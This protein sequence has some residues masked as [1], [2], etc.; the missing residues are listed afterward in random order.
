MIFDTAWAHQR[1]VLPTL[2]ARNHLLLWDP[3]TGKTLPLLAAAAARGGRCLYLLPP[4]VRTQV[5]R[6]A[7]RFGLF[8]P[9]DVQVVLRNADRVSLAAKLVVCSYEQCHTPALWRQLFALDWATLV[10]DEAHL[11]KNGETRRARAVYGARINSPGALAR[12]AERVLLA[13]GTPV[14]N[15]PSDLWMHISRVFPAVLEEL[16]IKSR[17]EWV[18]RYCATRQTPYGLQV[19]GG[20]NL[21]ELARVLKRIASRVRKDAVHDLPPL[22]VDQHWVPPTDIDLADVPDEAMAALAEL[23]AAERPD[24]EQLA[25]LA[26]PLASLRRRIGLAKAAH[27]AELV[28]GELRGGVAK[29]LVFYEH[30]DVA[31]AFL[32]AFKPRKGWGAAQY[33]GGLTPAQRDKA[34]AEFS[35]D[36]TCRLLL[37]QIQAAGTGLNL[38]AAERVVLLEP[39]WTPAL[40]EQAISRAYR[41]GQTRKTHA[42]YVC[43]EKS[44][45]ERIV[46]AIVRKTRVIAGV[47]DDRE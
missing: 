18:D 38:Q 22:I 17:A 33:S 5:A 14:V 45:D 24:T 29:A 16:S 21:P 25:R 9:E 20:K 46:G 44:V 10:C 15:D 4:S 13:T 36:P 2:I 37:A 23:L 40:N 34:V 1:D 6:E 26:V 42:S 19:T 28:A 47:L 3:G 7:V 27:V 12:K 32:Q 39:A 30:K 35:T 8:D 11:L 41:A 31:A 43:L